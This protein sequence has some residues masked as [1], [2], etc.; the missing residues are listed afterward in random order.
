MASARCVGADAHAVV[1]A[2]DAQR[3]DASR[4]TSSAVPQVLI[5]DLPQHRGGGGSVWNTVI[6]CDMDNASF[7]VKN[8][9]DAATAFAADLG[10]ARPRYALD[11]LRRAF[12]SAVEKLRMP[13]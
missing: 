11:D 1:E 7:P 8:A 12:A 5:V 2:V 6:M 10:V 13:W 9:D 4:A 3:V